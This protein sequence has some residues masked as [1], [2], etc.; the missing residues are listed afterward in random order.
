[1]VTECY[2]PFLDLEIWKDHAKA[3]GAEIGA[4]VQHAMMMILAEERQHLQHI[5]NILFF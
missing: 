5:G 3:L 1:M 4:S 2:G